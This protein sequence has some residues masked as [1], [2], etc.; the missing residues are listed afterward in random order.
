MDSFSRRLAAVCAIAAVSAMAVPAA[1]AATVETVAKGLDNPR[2][3]A[4]GPDGAVYVANTGRGGRQCQG[5]GEE[6][7]CVGTTGRI[8]RVAGGQKTTVAGGFASFAGAGGPFA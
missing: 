5:E 4:I 1:Q 8:V 2:S 7:M 6:A 3:V